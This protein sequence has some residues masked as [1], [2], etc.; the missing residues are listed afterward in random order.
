MN[1]KYYQ[2]VD[3]GIQAI[4]NINQSNIMECQHF[5]D[6]YEVHFTVSDN[7]KF[8]IDNE[9]YE[10]PKGSVFIIDSF[11]PH[12]T[13]V[14]DGAWFERYTIHI[15]PEV[16]EELNTF[17]DYDLVELFD[18]KEMGNACHIKLD[19]HG[20][21]MFE[22]LLSRQIDYLRADY[23]G[24]EVFQK[25]TLTEILFYLLRMRKEGVSQQ[26][27]GVSDENYKLAKKIIDYI[28]DNLELDLN[29]DVISSTFFRSKSTINRIFKQY[30]GT[31]V[32]QFI[33]SRRIYRAC[34]LLKENIPVFIVCEK[35]GFTD[36][37]HFIRVFK[38]YVG[39]TPKQYALQHLHTKTPTDIK[40][41]SISKK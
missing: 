34:E 13:L 19:Q 16:L 11:V 20:I 41:N 26:A 15:K 17:S 27:H 10:A 18:F 36:Y 40:S 33:S 8:I 37:N 25:L 32:N 7:L 30:C 14:P 12:M 28:L 31:T 23:F 35:S 21:L 24:A 1:D 5:H 9:L 2:P 3:K 29:L 38:K 4:H 22:S 39:I 6:S